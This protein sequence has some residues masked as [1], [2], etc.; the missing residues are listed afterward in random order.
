M[1]AIDYVVLEY[2]EIEVLLHLE[3]TF[4]DLHAIVHQLSL[5]IPKR[6]DSLPSWTFFSKII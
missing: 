5:G 4:Y 6:I 2:S 3:L 1:T